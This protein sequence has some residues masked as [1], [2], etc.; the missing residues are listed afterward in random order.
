ML[1]VPLAVQHL[2]LEFGCYVDVQM[3]R[4][5]CT[6]FAKHKHNF[7]AY[8]NLFLLIHGVQVDI[9]A[10][11]RKFRAQL[12]GS[13]IYQVMYGLSY[14]KSDLDIYLPLDSIFNEERIMAIRQQ[15][16]EYIRGIPLLE[17]SPEITAAHAVNRM[18]QETVSS[19]IYGFGRDLTAEEIDACNDK[20]TARIET[21]Q[22]DAKTIPVIA[23]GWHF[24]HEK[25]DYNFI[26]VRYPHKRLYIE[27]VIRDFDFGWLKNTYDGTNLR[28]LDWQAT[29]LKSHM[30]VLPPVVKPQTI[31]AS[32]GRVP[33]YTARGFKITACPKY[34]L[35]AEALL[36]C[37]CKPTL[38]CKHC[39]M[40]SYYL[41]EARVGLKM[42]K[43][44]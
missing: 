10:L 37:N 36:G 6:H 43:N 9:P 23:G 5:T 21:L 14:E 22:T 8:L 7:D 29:L 34:L 16:I 40:I 38:Y 3:M 32:I 13:T 42:L 17:L 31:T 35:Y 15:L 24:E 19:A 39:D 18:H 30:L 20:V 26:F 33:K 25:T 44:S 12:S 4:F 28:V 41:S 2:I 11:L 1:R 27:N